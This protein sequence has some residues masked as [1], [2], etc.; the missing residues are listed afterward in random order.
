MV[1]RELR[2]QPDEE[3]ANGGASLAARSICLYLLAPQAVI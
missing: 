1:L 3:P 2:A